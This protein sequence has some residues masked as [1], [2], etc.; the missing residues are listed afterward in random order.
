MDVDLFTY[1]QSTG[2]KENT[3]SRDAALAVE[4]SGK[5]ATLRVECMR[6]FNDGFTGTADELA[7]AMNEDAWS[8]RPRVSELH[9]RGLID[10][11]GDRRR[12]D[13]GRNAHVWIL[14]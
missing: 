12:A 5:A 7:H 8:I 4:A 13:G 10:K 14:A 11:T 9:K 2:W 3:T 6:R 1:P